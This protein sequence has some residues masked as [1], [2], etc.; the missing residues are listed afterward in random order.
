MSMS[1]DYRLSSGHEIEPN[2]SRDHALRPQ[3][4]AD[5]IGQGTAGKI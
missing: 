4:L 1:D 5:F 2:E 3:T